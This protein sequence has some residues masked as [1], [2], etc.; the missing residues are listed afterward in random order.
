MENSE[1]FKKVKQHVYVFCANILLTIT[2]VVLLILQLN[3]KDFNFMDCIITALIV[4]LLLI[5]VFEL[6]IYNQ[7]LKQ[8]LEYYY[9]QTENDKKR[10]YEEK[11][12]QFNQNYRIEVLKQEMLHQIVKEISVKTEN[13]EKPNEKEIKISIN[14]TIIEDIKKVKDEIDN[15]NN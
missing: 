11:L 1:L 10:A 12:S 15:I 5:F 8:L 4:I 6:W 9:T 3:G 13:T 2:G 14:H 7:R